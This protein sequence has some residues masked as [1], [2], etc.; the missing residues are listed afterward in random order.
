MERSR[1]PRN[2]PP[3]TDDIPSFNTLPPIDIEE[4]ETQNYLELFTPPE[5]ASQVAKDIFK[6]PEIREMSFRTGKKL[7]NL[8]N[9]AIKA[10][11]EAA[12]GQTRGHLAPTPCANCTKKTPKGPW[13]ECV[14][15]EG[16]F[17]RACCNCRYNNGGRACT[18]HRLNAAPN[19]PAPPKS[20]SAKPQ[21]SKPRTPSKWS[22]KA[23]KLLGKDKGKGKAVDKTQ[24][25]NPE[26]EKDPDSKGLDNTWNY[27]YQRD[28][29][30]EREAI[31][32]SR[33]NREA[34]Q[35][36]WEDLVPLD[37]N[38]EWETLDPW[39]WGNEVDYDLD[40]Q[41]WVD[42]EVELA[43]QDNRRPRRGP[44]GYNFKGG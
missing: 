25:Q 5:H 9:P 26:L 27:Q 43:I 16:K 12:Y 36:P 35:A 3:A 2:A 42:R 28:E 18:L 1:I 10:N 20:A 41:G 17:D 24:D 14:Q 37:D 40:Q 7:A 31:L 6:K 21:L 19:E 22:R 29:W 38:E 30:I 34:R 11:L 13:K 39:G 4:Q 8:N 32:A 44:W 23:D 15:V 33:Q